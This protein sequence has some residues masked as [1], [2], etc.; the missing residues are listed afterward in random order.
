MVLCTRIKATPKFLQLA[1]KVL[2]VGKLQELIDSLIINPEAG[3]L[4]S[5]TGGIRKLRW[6]TGK[7]N[8]GKSGGVR[9]LYY[10]DKNIC[11]VLLITLYKKSDQENIEASEKVYLKKILPELL[12][13]YTN[14]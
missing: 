14:E 2:T 9:I 1:R 5:G 7:N 13:N 8:K 12:R 4:I 10:Y 6:Q 11:I 3:L